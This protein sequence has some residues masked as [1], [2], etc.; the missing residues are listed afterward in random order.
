[1]NSKL[2]IPKTIMVGFQER[3]GTFTG[4]LAYIVYVDDK[5]VHRKKP[6]WDSWRNHQLGTLE[7]ENKPQTSFMFN[8]GIERSGSHFGSGRSVVRVHDERDFEFE[9]SVDNLIG[10]LMHSD[11]S[12]RDIVEECVYAWCGKDLVLLPT[13]SE[14]YR[15][16]VIHTKKQSKNL[17][18]K[19]FVK[20][21]TYS[22]K[23]NE[24]KL[25]YI[26]FRPWYQEESH[27]TLNSNAMSRRMLLKGNK[28][29]FQYTDCCEY[30]FERRT[31]IV[32]S[33]SQLAECILDEC[34]DDY[35]DRVIEFEKSRLSQPITGYKLTDVTKKESDAYLLA[36]NYSGNVSFFKEIETKGKF[37]T[38]D[39]TISYYHQSNLVS[40]YDRRH[41][42]NGYGNGRNR[43]LFAIVE[44]IDGQMIKDYDPDSASREILAR[45]ESI[46]FENKTETTRERL[47]Q[48]LEVTGFK[49][50]TLVC[51]NG[52]STPVRRY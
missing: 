31:F 32:P 14:Q 17:S 1:M 13:N 5:G 27:G 7:L 30:S 3:Y 11:V 26:G 9:I 22:M 24:N 52:T 45:Y 49:V 50:A 29:I 42:H 39:G 40:R 38:F 23:S 51:S 10:I 18:T 2:Y 36:N 20:G 43:N 25:I 46:I 37:V 35:A 47:L 4:K 12:K 6:S 16:S 41:F 48:Q 15:E 34:V 44:F 8:K 19:D 33:T 21:H 28:H